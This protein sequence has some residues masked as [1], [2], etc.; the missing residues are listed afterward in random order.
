MKS[1]SKDSDQLVPVFM[2]SHKIVGVL[3]NYFL[4]FYI[5]SE[6]VEFDLV[7]LV[8]PG[9]FT[10]SEDIKVMKMYLLIGPFKVLG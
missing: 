6:K 10:E 2:I 8:R 9:D 7:V 3:Y 1:S 5:L 4:I